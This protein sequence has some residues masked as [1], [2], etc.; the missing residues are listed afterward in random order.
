VHSGEE[1]LIRALQPSEA[2]FAQKTDHSFLVAP[3]GNRVYR[4]FSSGGLRQRLRREV[5]DG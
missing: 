2:R 1:K 5:L 3:C 4:D